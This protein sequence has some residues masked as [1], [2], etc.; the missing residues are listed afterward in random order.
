ME[1]RYGPILEEMYA[2]MEQRQR[3]RQ[4][5]MR[6]AAAQGTILDKVK[7][8][9]LSAPPSGSPSFET[10]HAFNYLSGRVKGC[11]QSKDA[12]SSSI[13]RY[14]LVGTTCEELGF[15]ATWQCSA[16]QIKYAAP[17]CKLLGE[18]RQPP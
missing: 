10:I 13:K 1:S 5:E 14:S 9:R 16:V 15:I 2:Q 8:A 18:C 17:W 3:E 12:S 11:L 7:Q 4:D 6:A